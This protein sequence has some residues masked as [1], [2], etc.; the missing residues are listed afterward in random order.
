MSTND[1]VAFWDGLY[2][3]RPA[4]TDPRP[5]AR[6]V[7]TVADL[8]PGDVLD[9]G[10]G[11]GGD[12]L[13]LARRGWR[14]TAVDIS[15]VAAER[16]TGRARA[17]GLGDLIDAAPHDL[18]VS[19]P[20]G[21]FDLICAHYLHTPFELDR[22]ALLRTAAHAL[23]PGGRL[24]VVDHG[25][26]APWSWNQDPDARYPTPREVAAGLGLDPATWP[27]ERA[28]APRRTATGPGGRTAEVVDHVL[29]VRRDG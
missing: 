28:D 26:T 7:E 18:R 2:A 29:I 10:C 24:L 12:A 1:A 13:W 14:V 25:S 19:F 3:A 6:L 20:E 16:L 17:Q 23:R 4:A 21:R 5:N 8:P 11:D 22:S 9:L 15:P 27:V